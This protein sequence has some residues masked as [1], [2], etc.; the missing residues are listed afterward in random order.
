MHRGWTV[1]G[2]VS[3]QADFYFSWKYECEKSSEPLSRN[4][5][6]IKST[7]SFKFQAPAQWSCI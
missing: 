5:P 3:D 2:A 6:E 7:A 4:F 1:L